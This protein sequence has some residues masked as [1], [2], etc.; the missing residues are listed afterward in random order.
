MVPDRWAG[1]ITVP[2]RPLD[3]LVSEHGIPDFVKIDVEGYE[4][5]VLA[6]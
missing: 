4:L 2:V 6:G 3:S 5:Q 1:S